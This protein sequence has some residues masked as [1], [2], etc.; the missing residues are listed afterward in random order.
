MAYV[1]FKEGTHRSDLSSLDRFCCKGISGMGDGY[2]CFSVSIFGL[3][4][5]AFGGWVMDGWA[6]G[7]M[8][9]SANVGKG[10]S[11]KKGLMAG[12][13]EK[14]GMRKGRCWECSKMV[15]MVTSHPL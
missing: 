5:W 11:T 4:S 9:C 13:E 7:W 1:A 8:I 15:M 3:I 10:D 2:I 6:N 14:K 12:T